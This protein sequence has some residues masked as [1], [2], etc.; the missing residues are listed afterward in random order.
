MLVFVSLVAAFLGNWL[1]IKQ[2][3][4]SEHGNI[5]YPIIALRKL[6]SVSVLERERERAV[7]REREREREW[8][9]WWLDRLADTS[10]SVAGLARI[11]RSC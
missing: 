4:R 7:L 8:R 9:R 3:T 10:L 2:T 5:S 6:C 11:G 1:L